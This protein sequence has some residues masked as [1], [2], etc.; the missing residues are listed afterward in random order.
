M[1]GIASPIGVFDSGV[2]GI[3]V[4]AALDLPQTGDRSGLAQWAALA[5]LCAGGVIALL[6]RRKRA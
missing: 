6:A 4:L 3:S 1:A 2:G 5:L